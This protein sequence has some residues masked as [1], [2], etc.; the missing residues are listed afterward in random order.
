[1]C[2]YGNTDPGFLLNI[3]INICIFE[4]IAHFKPLVS[5]S[6]QKH[7]TIIKKKKWKNIHKKIHRVFDYIMLSIQ[8]HFENDLLLY[9][10]IIQI[11]IYPLHY[12]IHTT[13]DS[14]YILLLLLFIRIVQSYIFITYICFVCVFVCVSL[15]S[16]YSKPNGRSSFL[17]SRPCAKYTRFILNIVIICK[18]GI[19]IIF[20]FQCAIAI[21]VDH[22]E[23]PVP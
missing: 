20:M 2:S 21:L 3:C 4:N 18:I 15:R 8:N 19:D 11:Y 16:A 1:M 22:C 6:P 5:H 7:Q 10:P 23:Y 12:R 17:F 14:K 9:L 13:C